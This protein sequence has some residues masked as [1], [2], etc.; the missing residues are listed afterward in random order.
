MIFV[1]VGKQKTVRPE[2]WGFGGRLQA[3]AVA[4]IWEVLTCGLLLLASGT[5]SL[6]V[7]WGGSTGPFRPYGGLLFLGKVGKPLAPA[8]G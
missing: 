6:S 4:Q 7:W 2:E 1:V 5:G 3:G 8:S